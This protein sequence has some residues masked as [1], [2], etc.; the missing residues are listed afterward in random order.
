MSLIASLFLEARNV[1]RSTLQP[2]LE[3]D[4]R[5]QAAMVA[6]A[7]AIGARAADT[8]GFP[9]WSDHESVAKAARAGEA[10]DIDALK[11][12]VLSRLEVA[13]PGYVKSLSKD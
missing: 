5:F 9:T 2:S 6:N 1:L 3:G 7:L 10:I 13:S 8:G 12:T 4:D 11:T